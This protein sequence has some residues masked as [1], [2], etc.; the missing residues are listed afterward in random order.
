MKWPWRKIEPRRPHVDMLGLPLTPAEYAGTVT[1]GQRRLHS[2]K[3]WC[4]R[5]P[6]ES[7]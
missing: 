5:P 1:S 3:C 6:R 7:A 4:R 2:P